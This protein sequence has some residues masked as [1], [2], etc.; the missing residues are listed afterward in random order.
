MLRN[1]NTYKNQLSFN[2][3][4]ESFLAQ[5]A[6]SVPVFENVKVVTMRGGKSTHDPPHPNN[7][8]IALAA[9]CWHFL[10]QSL[11]MVS[12]QQRRQE[13]P[14]QSPHSGDAMGRRAVCLN[15]HSRICKRTDIPL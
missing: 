8:G 9:Q 14:G 7:T 4:V 3:K 10:A 12:S 5:I 6:A 1:A 2:K 11:G 15:D 13:M